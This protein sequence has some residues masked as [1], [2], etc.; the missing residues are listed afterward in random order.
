MKSNQY[1]ERKAENITRIEK[2]VAF[3]ISGLTDWSKVQKQWLYLEPI[4]AQ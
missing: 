4:F 1:A 2:E 3:L